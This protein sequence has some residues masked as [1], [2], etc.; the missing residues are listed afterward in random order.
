MPT[1]HELMPDFLL[2][3]KQSNRSAH[4]QRAYEGDLRSLADFYTGQLSEIDSEILRR[5]FAQ[6][7]V[8]KPAT[9][10]RKQAAVA[11]F[12][13]WAY[14]QDMIA[15]NPMERVKRIGLT[16]PA[17]RGVQRDEVERILAKVPAHQLRDQ[18][19]FRL[20]LETGL[21]ISEALH[22]YVEDLDLTLDNERLTVMGKGGRV[23]TVLL[24]DPY[25]VKLLRR[26]LKK[27][28]FQRGPLFRASKNGRGGPLRYQSIQAR[29]QGYCE[30][31]EIECT[32][33]QLRHTHAT[34]LING[35]VSLNTIRKRLGH[36]HMQTTLRYAE[37]SD[38]SA[39]NELR[40]WRRTQS[41]SK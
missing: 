8:L 12:L 24:E 40:T 13:K 36:K 11:S 3:L 15:A 26:Y 9:R 25:L 37:Q 6:H 1:I 5:F 29:W 19:L 34:E 10:A 22:L 17:P 18:L 14:Q 23:R 2:E 21:R 28:G 30:L 32:L 31:A 20:L 41:T 7:V 39:D 35:G 38:E 4:T 16:P 33:H 27:T